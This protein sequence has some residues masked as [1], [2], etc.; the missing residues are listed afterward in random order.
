MLV[1][2]EH[3]VL[4]WMILVVKAPQRRP[5]VLF[6]FSPSRQLTLGVGM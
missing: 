5:G 6:S 4:Q 3:S 2:R 1:K